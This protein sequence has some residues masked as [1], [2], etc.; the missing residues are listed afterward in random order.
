MPLLSALILGLF[1]GL[2][3]FFTRWFTKKIAFAAAAVAAF[4][5]LT[6]TL[7]GVM[8]AA[9]AAIAVSLPSDPGVLLGLWLAIPDNGPAVVS[10]VFAFDAALALYRWNVENLKLASY[11]T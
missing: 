11:V 4:T 2:A 6:V 5:A 9:I 7:W 8:T 3:D 1:T 10:A